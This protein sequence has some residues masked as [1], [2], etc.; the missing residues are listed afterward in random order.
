MLKGTL[1]I[2]QFYQS[3][4][5]KPN[6]QMLKGIL[7][8]LPIYQLLISKAN[9]QMLKVTSCLGQGPTGKPSPGCLVMSGFWS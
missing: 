4:I 6:K 1:P 8:I 2:Y 9:K 5:S 7:P 3:L